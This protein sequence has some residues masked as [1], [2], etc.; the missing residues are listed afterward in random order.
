MRFSKIRGL[1]YGL[2]YPLSNQECG[3]SS[4]SHLP[5]NPRTSHNCTSPHEEKHQY[6]KRAL[7]AVAD[8]KRTLRRFA[9]SEHEQHFWT[10][11]EKYPVTSSRNASRCPFVI[12]VVIFRNR[13]ANRKT[14]N[15]T[16]A[17]RYARQLRVEGYL[18]KPVVGSAPS[19]GSW[20]GARAFDPTSLPSW[21]WNVTPA[22]NGR[23]QRKKKNRQKHAGT[24][25]KNQR[26]EPGKET[27]A[28]PTRTGRTPDTKAVSLFVFVSARS[29]VGA[30]CSVL[31]SAPEGSALNPP[32]F[33]SQ[34]ELDPRTVVKGVP[35]LS[36]KWKLD[37][38]VGL[39]RG[40]EQ[41][42]MKIDVT[43]VAT[44][45]HDASNEK[46]RSSRAR[47]SQRAQ[48]VLKQH[49]R[50]MTK[51]CRHLQLFN[52]QEGTLEEDAPNDVSQPAVPSSE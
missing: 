47:H 29:G 43:S 25:K 24:G 13:V 1:T 31:G 49:L 35:L 45:P 4:G 39:L 48:K 42:Q 14:K 26:P 41:G 20:V 34:L 21:S 19:T 33:Q 38:T 40:F 2:V 23:K 8:E 10:T 18:K 46:R 6:S 7:E 51:K 50:K 28:G 30:L 3:N 5:G 16:G 17:T 9:E 15:K 32:P 52:V 27:P 44:P 36:P 37:H 22:A 11:D 12:P